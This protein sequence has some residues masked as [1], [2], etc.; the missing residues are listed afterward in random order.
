MIKQLIIDIAY[1]KISVSQALTRAKLIANQ[2]KNETFKNWLSK[3]LNGYD[4]NDEYLPKYR[5][6]M[7]EI[8][9]TAE[10]PFER[11]HTFAALLADDA[12][13]GM[14]EMIYFHQ[15]Q[16]PIS[17]LEQTMA[18][19]QNSVASIVLPAGLTQMV[20]QLY[21]EQL[22]S[23]GGVVR[24]GKRRI[25][26]SQLQNIVEL[27][28]QKLIDTLQELDN[29]FPDL[30]DNYKIT[31]DNNE[32]V[33]NI[34]TNNIYGNNNPMNVAVGQ[35]I[36][37]TDISFNLTI[38]QKEEL[39]SYGVEDEQIEELETITNENPKNS[40][41]RKTRIM[42]WLGK[43]TASLAARGIYENIP[44]LTEFIGGLV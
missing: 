44:E 35:N 32:K 28:K 14:K 4:Y 11:T 10:F 3:E 12:A 13:E 2:L 26:K 36:T 20:A 6:L 27:T 29:Q 21:E 39:K 43:V 7:A 1:D 15:V 30:E 25:A 9:L 38:S 41:N 37:Q 40:P 24:S 17:V 23:Q 42:G 22:E 18:D 34:I 31:P 33:S 5:K 16:D 19:M 8:Q